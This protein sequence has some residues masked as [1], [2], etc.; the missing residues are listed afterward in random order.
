MAKVKVLLQNKSYKR[1]ICPHESFRS[2]RLVSQLKA[3]IKIGFRNWWNRW[4]FNNRLDRPMHLPDALRQL[5]LYTLVDEAFKKEFNSLVE[6][7]T[8]HN[9]KGYTRTKMFFTEKP[10]HSWMSMSLREFLVDK[11]KE[12]IKQLLFGLELQPKGFAVIAPGSVW[13]TKRWTTNG[14]SQVCRHFFKRNQKVVLVGS[15][16][17]AWIAEEIEKETPQ[18]INLVGKTSL[19]E[20]LL[21][22]TQ[23]EGFIGNDS[24]TMHLAAIADVPIVSIFGPTTLDLG[25]R[26]WTS[27]SAVVQQ[28]LACRPCGLHGSK[29]CPLHTHACMKSIKPDLVIQTYHLVVNNS[30]RVHLQD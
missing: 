15:P 28:P 27:K 14:F 4:V 22:M 21:L 2:A 23:A 10:R 3:P 16:E 13:D 6:D 5:S 17:E 26:P 29:K 11:Y 12:D 7:R 24:G 1:I 25:Y 19:F 18:I 30:E 20:C 8:F 9:A